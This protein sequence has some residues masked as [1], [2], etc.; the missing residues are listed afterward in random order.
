M[1]QNW[2][3][4]A[5]ICIYEDKISSIKRKLIQLSCSERSVTPNIFS[6]FEKVKDSPDIL[7][8]QKHYSSLRGETFSHSQNKCKI[9]S[10]KLV[11]K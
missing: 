5:G 10:G 9:V 6:K 3:W 1:Q 11:Q 7:L 8:I 4:F 2:G